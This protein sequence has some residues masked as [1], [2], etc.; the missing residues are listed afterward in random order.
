MATPPHMLLASGYF[1]IMVGGL[2]W[3][4]SM[5]NRGM[6]ASRVR[7]TWLFLAVGSIGV[8]QLSSSIADPTNMHTA[9]FYLAFALNIPFWMI[10]CGW[11][12]ANKWGC[13]IVAAFCTSILLAAEW[14]LPLFPAQP[15]FA[16]VYHQVTH[17]IPPGFPQLLIVPAFL[18]DLLLRRS[19][20]RSSWIKAIWIGP[21]FVLSFFV[22]Q[23]PF[24]N[25]L[26]SPASRN[27]I[28]G[29]GYFDYS[30]LYDPY[31]FQVAE[32]TPGAFLLTIAIACVASILTTRFGLAWGNWMR[33]ICR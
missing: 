2:A 15:K 33:R 23:W 31:K 10:G 19:E 32:K 13:T 25:F 27:W 20:Q 28:F 9:A 17:L 29:T 24:A 18:A 12:S 14:L 7:L 22:V 26:L 3:I 11:G 21:A 16:P 4:A 8:A 30:V 5:M 1:V 6:G